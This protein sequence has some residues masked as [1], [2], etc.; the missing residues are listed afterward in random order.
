MPA[1]NSCTKCVELNVYTVEVE[2]IEHLG[3]HARRHVHTMFYSLSDLVGLTA[4]SSF[5]ST[6]SSFLPFKLDKPLSS[7]TACMY[8]H[9]FCLCSLGP[10]VNFAHCQQ[11]PT[12]Q[13]REIIIVANGQIFTMGP[14]EQNQHFA[15][16]RQK[17][18]LYIHAVVQLR[19]LPSLEG[20][21]EL[22]VGK[23]GKSG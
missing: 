10:I 4:F 22:F 18:C 9:T 5:F 21:N 6:K 2:V 15:E 17:V 1:F 11:L 7:T 3:T 12:V 13:T 14:N 16:F 19:G 20:K 23:R 8:K